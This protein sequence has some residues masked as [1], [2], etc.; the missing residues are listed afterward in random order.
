MTGALDAADRD[1]VRR[2]GRHRRW[3]AGGVLF[4]E[5]DE[6]S[7]VYLVEEGHLKVSCHLPDGHEV[8]LAVFGPGEMV[9]E[10]SALDQN[11]RSG[12]LSALG[13]AATTSLTAAQ[14]EEFLLVHPSRSISLLRVVSG[15]LRQADVRSVEHATVDLPGRLAARIVELSLL[16][17]QPM[18]GAATTLCVN[19]SHDEL[20]AWTA[21]SRE[22]VSKAM[23]GFRREGLVE[24]ARRQILVPDI[25]AL[26][27]RSQRRVTV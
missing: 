9:G 7:D 5:G 26:R 22:A 3:S 21:S 4:R 17:G 18:P 25:A 15:R 19:V 2:R 10:L 20:A 12:T 14:F 27:K 1:D 11:P 24:T 6:S 16:F 13:P 23:A 8:V